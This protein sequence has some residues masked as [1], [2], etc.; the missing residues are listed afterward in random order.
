AGKV[1]DGT[2][3]IESSG[4]EAIA[5]A[6]D[7]TRVAYAYSYVGDDAREATAKTREDFAGFLGI[8]PEDVYVP[9]GT[10]AE[11]AAQ[12]DAL[13]DAGADS[14]VL[15][16]LGSAL[17]EQTRRALDALRTSGYRPARS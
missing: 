1:A 11:F 6:P 8:A 12:V 7:S 5:N 2:V 16:P 15:H 9:S 10:P 17:A 4:P 13:W 14:V 3:L